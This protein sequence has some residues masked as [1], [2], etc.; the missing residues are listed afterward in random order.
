MLLSQLPEIPTMTT[1]PPPPAFSWSN[2]LQ[3]AVP[4][5]MQLY[6]ER[7]ATKLQMDRARQGLP[8][9]PIE[10]YSPPVRVEAGVDPRTQTLV[11]AGLGVAAGLGLVLLLGKRR[12]A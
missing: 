10:F 4:A 11:L 8:P 12:R 9:L 7:Q 2:L 6:R 5:A 3:T 1:P